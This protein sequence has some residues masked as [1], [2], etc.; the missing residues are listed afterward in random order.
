MLQE[1][2]CSSDWSGKERYLRKASWSGCKL[3]VLQGRN[4]LELEDAVY[5][6]SAKI[7]FEVQ[8]RFGAG[9]CASG[10]TRA[11]T[12]QFNFLNSTNDRCSHSRNCWFL[13][14]RSSREFSIGI[15]L[16]RAPCVRK[17]E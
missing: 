13:G 3:Q 7:D 11:F 15:W 2:L 10:D 8:K 9:S 17:H 1:D 14:V 5:S 4:R 6:L 16:G 12:G